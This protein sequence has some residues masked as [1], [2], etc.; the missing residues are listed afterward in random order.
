MAATASTTTLT[1]GGCQKHAFALPPFLRPHERRSGHR[2][3]A[4]RRAFCPSHRLRPALDISVAGDDPVNEVDPSGL[5]TV[6]SGAVTAAKAAFAAGFTHLLVA[7]V[8]IAGA[9]T[10]WIPTKINEGHYG[11][12]Q[13]ALP[14]NSKQCPFLTVSNFS[15][16]YINADCAMQ[17]RDFWGNAEGLSPWIG[18]GVVV[19]DAATNASINMTAPLPACQV[20]G[21]PTQTCWAVAVAALKKAH[22]RRYI[23]S[24][25]IYATLDETES[26]ECDDNS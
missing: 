13:I 3:P 20:A 19:A 26:V 23:P 7:M 24:D 18:D 15:N 14:L 11:L 8:A 9:E 22:L 6:P 2:V 17:L 25:T 5:V 10:S 12:W 16:P 21:S 4:R 1:T